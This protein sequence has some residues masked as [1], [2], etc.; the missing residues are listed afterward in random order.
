[1]TKEQFYYEYAN[2]PL[3]K[4]YQAINLEKYGLMTFAELN[5]EV[6]RIDDKIRPDVIEQQ[7]LIKIFENSLSGFL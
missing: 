5:K 7:N 4:R 2:M 1:M 6:K 3:D